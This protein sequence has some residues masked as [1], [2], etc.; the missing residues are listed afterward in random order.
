MAH[1]VM[2]NTQ[3]VYVKVAILGSRPQKVVNPDVKS[4][5]FIQSNLQGRL[6]LGKIFVPVYSVLLNVGHQVLEEVVRARLH[7]LQAV[8]LL[9]VVLRED[10]AP[11]TVLFLVEF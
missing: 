8:H 5:V 9:P 6:V 4:L 10:V 11:I 1:P 7:H 3:P 2:A